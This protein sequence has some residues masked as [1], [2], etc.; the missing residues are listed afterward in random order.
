MKAKQPV[1]LIT[2]VY[3]GDMLLKE[4]HDERAA[5]AVLN[6]IAKAEH[7]KA[8]PEPPAQEEP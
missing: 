1:R 4:T 7:G 6:H 8:L 2:R 3:A 5:V